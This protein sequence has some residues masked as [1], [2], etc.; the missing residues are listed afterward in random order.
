MKST[1]PT[2]H[3]IQCAFIEWCHLNEKKYPGLQLAFAVPNGGIRSKIT[4]ANLKKEGV[5]PGVPD[6][7]CPVSNKR[8]RGMAIEFKRPGGHITPPQREY[9]DA[10]RDKGWFVEVC[11]DAEDACQM[12]GRYFES[13]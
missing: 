8:F 12:V 6:W 2:E 10:L 13:C 4:A 11:Y 9:I 3:Q 1:E 7:M 5:R